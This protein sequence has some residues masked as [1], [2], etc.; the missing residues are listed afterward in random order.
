V[1]DYGGAIEVSS[2]VGQGSKF[3]IYLPRADAPALA[4]DE[5]AG[6]LARGNGEQVLLVDDE[7]ALLAVTSEVL[8]RLG[9]EPVAFRDAAAALAEF[10]AAPQ[11][12]DAVI[13][14]E[15]MPGLTGTELA[16]S[17]RARRAGLAIVLV[18]G[19]IG[20]MMT[21]RAMTAGVDE[22]LKKPVQ[23]RALAEALDRALKKGR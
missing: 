22:I 2:T 5:T 9:Y 10:E 13:V 23:S 4:D 16:R 15:V 3:T 11:R 12:F 21:E 7:E 20:P 8:K 18:S 6:P 17:L 19:Y 1:T 14:D